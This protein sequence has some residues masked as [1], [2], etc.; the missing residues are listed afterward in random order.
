MPGVLVLAEHRRKAIQSITFEMLS[1]GREVAAQLKKEVS[2]VLLGHQV[3]AF[4][5]ELAKVAHKVYVIDDK[6]LEN[7]N[8]ELYQKALVP[9]MKD[10]KPTLTLIGH[11]SCGMDLA[12]A[13]AVELGFPLVTDCIALERQG[14]KV[15]ATRQV[16]GGKINVRVSAPS[17]QQ[18]MATIRQAAFPP[19]EPN[20]AGGIVSVP[21]PLTEDIDYKKFLEYVEVAAG[22]V[23]ITASNVLVAIGRGIKEQ[24]NVQMAQDLAAALGGVLA[25]SRPVVDAGWLPHDRQVGSSGKNVKPKLYIALGISGAFQHVAGLRG[26]ETVIAVNKDANAPIFSVA[27][28]GIVGDL[29]KV[30]PVLKDKLLEMKK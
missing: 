1:R 5:Q 20:L 10:L 8:A 6:R 21:S 11:T 17:A 27:Q 2:V 4:A 7:F 23:D 15:V 12:P 22:D 9:F 16:Y 18:G 29:F 30:I 3:Q 28:Y 25:C 19:A 13:L 26:V 14:K 24:K